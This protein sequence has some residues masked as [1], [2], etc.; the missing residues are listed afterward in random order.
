MSKSKANW[1]CAC[2]RRDPN[3]TMNA[4]KVHPITTKRCRVCGAERPELGQYYCSA[5]G[6]LLDRDSE[7][8][9]ITSY[10]EL[11]GRPVRLYRM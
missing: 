4:I 3:G 5:C 2:V 7:K 11:A 9:W 6:K 10:C 1:P 8:A